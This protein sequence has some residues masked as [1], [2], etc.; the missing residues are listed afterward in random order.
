MMGGVDNRLFVYGTLAPGASNAHVLAGL[1]GQWQRAWV[2]GR[3][4][5]EGCAASFGY[6][7]L[8]LAGE[9]EPDAELVEGLLFSSADLPQHW[10]RLDAFEG[11]AYR[12]VTARLCLEGGE[13]LDAW[14][15][16]V[17]NPGNENTGK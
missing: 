2:R 7:A 14:V 4:Y 11:E 17:K 5:P 16:E 3:H 12:R 9:D 1:Q 8:F 15:Y 13:G 6:P 10:P